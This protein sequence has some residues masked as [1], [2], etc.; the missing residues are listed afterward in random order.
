MGDKSEVLGNAQLGRWAKNEANTYAPTGQ[1]QVALLTTTDAAYDV[2]PIGDEVDI[3]TDDTAYVRQNVNFY[4]IVNTNFTENSNTITFPPVVLGTNAVDFDIVG[5]AIVDSTDTWLYKSS[6]ISAVTLTTGS[7]LT[8]EIRDIHVSELNKPLNMAMSYLRW[9]LRGDTSGIQ[10]VA[11]TYVAL[12]VSDES[13]VISEIDDI[14]YSSTYDRQ[15]VTW[16]DIGTGD[17]TYNTNLVQFQPAAL[18]GLSATAGYF[19]ITHVA[20]YDALT[21]GNK[22]WERHVLDGSLDDDT[23]TV[24]EDTLVKFVE[25]DDKLWIGEK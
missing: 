5:I 2:Q 8:F 16:N 7:E 14:N 19:V 17:S 9:S 10:P 25:N 13:G 11:Q 22:M 12:M 23:I 24:I 6:L 18:V 21:G 1:L 20:I 3:V 15:A 4:D